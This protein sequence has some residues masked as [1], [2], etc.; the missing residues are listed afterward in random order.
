MLRY[1][2]GVLLCLQ[3][4]PHKTRCYHSTLDSC[5]ISRE[6]EFY[7]YQNENS[8]RKIRH[9]NSLQKHNNNIVNTIIQELFC[10]KNPSVCIILVSFQDE[11][12]TAARVQMYSAD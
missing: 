12:T 3:S 4:Q 5:T 6:L 11:V 8:S 2:Y 9:S 10:S 7:S 1:R